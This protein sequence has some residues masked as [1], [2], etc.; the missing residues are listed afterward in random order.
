MIISKSSLNVVHIAKPDKQVPLL[1]TVHITE[2]GETVAANRDSV[3]MVSPVDE[4]I[5]NKYP[6]KG[7]ESEAITLTSESVNDII[8]YIG[9][10]RVFEGTLEHCDI[11]NKN[12]KAE[13]ICY[14]GKRTK[15]LEGKAYP[16][17]FDYR[18]L[19][20]RIQSESIDVKVTLN[21]KRLLS[22]L[23]TIEKV[24]PDKGDF[25]PIYLE[26]TK[27]GD[28]I[29]RAKNAKFKQKVLAVMRGIPGVGELEYSEWEKQFIKREKDTTMKKIIVRQRVRATK[30]I[31]EV[32]K[33]I[34]LMNKTSPVKLISKIAVRKRSRVHARKV[35][36]TYNLLNAKWSIIEYHCD[37][38]GNH[39]RQDSVSGMYSC[40]FVQCDKY[41]KAFSEHES[42]SIPF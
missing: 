13:V 38:C 1:D 2:Q 15:I 17:Y 4:E 16:E 7:K 31:N 18:S 35:T 33:E 21:R 9:T 5:K 11:V 34:T 19:F 6:V 25:A 40:S 12:G 22:L 3:I 37:V 14:D 27:N 42:W 39:L 41:N 32:A 36:E 26:F 20:E 30:D 28:V 10:D 23:N 8:H 24:C 29:I